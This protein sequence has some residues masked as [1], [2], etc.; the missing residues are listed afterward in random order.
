MDIIKVFEKELEK[1]R[2]RNW[3]C[4]YVLLDIHGTIF[5]PSYNEEEL[6]LYY[7]YAKE[8]LQAISRIKYIKLILWS[9]TKKDFLYNYFLQLVDDDIYID[10]FNFNDEVKEEDCNFD[11][12]SFKYKTYFNVGIDDRFGFEPEKDWKELYYYFMRTN[13]PF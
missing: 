4:I 3:D 12:A 8:T 11:T 2:E 10:Y 5:V 1:M 7:P 9:S 13:L 6:Y